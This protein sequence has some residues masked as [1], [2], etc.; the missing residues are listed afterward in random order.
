MDSQS[1][2]CGGE[3]GGESLVFVSGWHVVLVE[4]VCGLALLQVGLFLPGCNTLIILLP[5]VSVRDGKLRRISAG[6]EHSPKS[7]SVSAVSHFAPGRA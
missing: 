3:E 4:D 5:G 2:E 1:A 7:G 6:M